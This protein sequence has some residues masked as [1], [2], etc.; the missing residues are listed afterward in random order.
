MAGQKRYA[1]VSCHVERLLDDAVWAA[2]SRLQERAPSGFRIA[3]LVRPP[4]E[5]AGEDPEEWLRRARRAASQGPFGHH[6]HWGGREQAR[7]LG[8]DPAGRVLREGEW[9]RAA[10]LRPTL[11]CGG[12]WYLD[13]DVAA[14]AAELGYADCTATSFRPAVSRRGRA[15]ARRARAVPARARRG[16]SAARASDD[17]HARD[18]LSERA[19]SPRARR[20]RRAR[21]FSRLR[22][23]RPPPQRRPH[24]RRSRCSRDAAGRPTSIAC[25]PS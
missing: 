7:P 2:F 8:G 9:L 24:R 3:A 23:A 25:A 17:A 4:D 10:G 1:V 13:G 14:A 20:A 19:R 21:L 11:F 18:A 12:G 15:E 5:R 22:P 16:Q 6:T